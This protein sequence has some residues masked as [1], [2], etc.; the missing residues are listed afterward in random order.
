MPT[1]NIIEKHNRKKEINIH[2]MNT[3]RDT[4]ITAL[5]NV[6]EF[7]SKIIDANDGYLENLVQAD[8]PEYD[9]LNKN[10]DMANT[11]EE[12][13]AIRTR[14]AEM[15]SERYKKDTENKEFYK[16]QQVN[17][18]NYTLQI[19]VFVAVIIGGGVVYKFRKPIMEVSKKLINEKSNIL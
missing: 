2:K 19:L 8:K 3:Y 17:H 11:P 15:N 10:M 5:E 6:F 1:R 4:A 7:D 13:E 18:K 14:M 12:R 16:N 9:I